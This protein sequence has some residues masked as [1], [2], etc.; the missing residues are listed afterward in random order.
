[1][2]SQKFCMTCPSLCVG[3]GLTALGG[4]ERPGRGVFGLCYATGRSANLAAAT[5]RLPRARIVDRHEFAHD[6]VRPCGWG[7][8]RHACLGVLI[9][10]MAP[11]RESRLTPTGHVRRDGLPRRFR[12]STLRAC[13]AGRLALEQIPQR[14]TSTALGEPRTCARGCRRGSRSYPQF[15]CTNLTPS[16]AQT[17]AVNTVLDRCQL[18]PFV[19]VLV[20]TSLFTDAAIAYSDGVLAANPHATGTLTWKGIDYLQTSV[21]YTFVHGSSNF[22]GGAFSLSLI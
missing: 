14:G 21:Q 5:A 19:A 17:L 22:A 9:R 2:K 11:S 12:S 6:G 15:R 8:P 18:V 13:G 10:A 3:N 7:V 16:C 4:H 20:G 1:M